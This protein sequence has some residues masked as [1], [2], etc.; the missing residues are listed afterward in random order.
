MECLVCESTDDVRVVA[1]NLGPS[2]YPRCATCQRQCAETHGMICLTHYLTRGQARLEPELRCYVD[3]RYAPAEVA[4]Q[5][6]AEYE[7][8]FDADESLRELRMAPP[9]RDP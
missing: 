2:S 9:T 4:L 7:A 8:H 5:E 3:G 6:F 1:S